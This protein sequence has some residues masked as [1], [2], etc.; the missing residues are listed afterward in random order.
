MTIAVLAS[1]EQKKE[2]F[3]KG[4]AEDVEVLWCGSVKTLV[5][6][7]ADVYVDLQFVFDRERMAHY[8]MREG[9]PF[10]VNAVEDTAESIGHG[11]IRINAWKG[12][13]KRDL[14]EVAIAEPDQE[15][16]VEEVMKLLGW[17]YIIVPDIAGMVTARVICSIINEA[18][19]TYGDGISSKEEI[20]IAM[21]LGTKY[22]FGPFEWAE[23]IGI[24][25]VYA[26]LK[27]M[28]IESSRYDV[29]PSLL[30]EIKI[31]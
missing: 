24:D 21:K 26:L 3:E 19:Y 11:I 2:W 27:K 5:A 10:F 12:M 4:V 15:I 28:N 13:L 31:R 14:V 29:A 30:E 17:K 25:K 7:S 22:P 1:E 18:Y 20:D 8:K 23:Q 9:F 6:T 16:V